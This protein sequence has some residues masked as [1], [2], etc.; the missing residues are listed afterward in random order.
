[1]VYGVY[2]E[3]GAIPEFRRLQRRSSG[4]LLYQACMS[5]TCRTH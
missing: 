2:A 3:T 4:A 1:M 5:R